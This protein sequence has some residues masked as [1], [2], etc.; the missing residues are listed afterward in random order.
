[1]HDHMHN[2]MHGP[3]DHMTKHRLYVRETKWLHAFTIETRAQLRMRVRGPRALLESAWTTLP[4]HTWTRA[5]LHERETQWL[6]AFTRHT[7]SCACAYAVLGRCVNQ[8][9]TLYSITPRV[10]QAPKGICS[11]DF[12]RA[13]PLV[14]EAQHA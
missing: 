5:P 11:R 3:H 9:Y 2:H 6:H 14:V 8:P 13:M 12:R 10:M 1:M 4:H 7:R